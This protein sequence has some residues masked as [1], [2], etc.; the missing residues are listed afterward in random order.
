MITPRST[1]KERKAGKGKEERKKEKGKE[2]GTH[3]WKEQWIGR[4]APP[5][6]KQNN[7]TFE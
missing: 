5:S 2:K 7:V 3:R 6:S 4:A 1:Q